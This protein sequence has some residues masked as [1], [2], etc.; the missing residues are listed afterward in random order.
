MDQLK[1]ASL[2]HTHY[3]YEVGMLKVPAEYNIVERPTVILSTCI[4]HHADDTQKHYKQGTPEAGL[5]YSS[6]NIVLILAYYSVD[7]V[8]YFYFDG[9]NLLNIIVFDLYL[10]KQG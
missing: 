4:N 6:S 1:F 2:S 10:R 9:G 5:E 7:N 3:W 8:H